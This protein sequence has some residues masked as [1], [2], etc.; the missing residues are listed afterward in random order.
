MRHNAKIDW[1]IALLAVAGVVAPLASRTYWASGLVLGILLI[2]I[3][4]QSYETTTRGL[5]IRAGVTRR[6]VP[7][8]TIRF[9]GPATQGAASVAL[10]SAQV[11]IQW[12]LAS[13]VLIAPANA[14]SFLADLSAH[15]PHLARRGAALVA[16]GV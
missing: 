15:A 5:L 3:F 13:E 11:K 4:P 10:S 6:L 2:T 8:G 1:W 7:Y 14:A 12:G 9:A 16:V